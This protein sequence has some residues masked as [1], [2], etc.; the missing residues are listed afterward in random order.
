LGSNDE[1][2]LGI[3]DGIGIGSDDSINMTSSW[4]QMIALSLALK[5]SS[6][7]ALMLAT[8]SYNDGIKLSSQQIQAWHQ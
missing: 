2:E 3:K 8:S 6:S 5:M 4:A 1:F 7:W